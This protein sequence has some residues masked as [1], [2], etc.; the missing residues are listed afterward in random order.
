MNQAQPLSSFKNPKLQFVRELLRDRKARET[1][2]LFVV[3]GVRL[4]EEALR[5]PLVKPHM[6]LISPNLSER[7]RKLLQQKGFEPN[8]LIKIP[9]DVMDRLSDTET[10]QGVLLVIPQKIELLP[11]HSNLV[12]ILDQ[13]RDPGNMGTILR[14]AAA[15]GVGSVFTAPGSVDPYNP[16]VVR[17]AMGAHFH[18]PIIQADWSQIRE[19][20]KEKQTPPL[21][22]ILAEA[23]NGE[24][25]W[26]MNLAS[27]LAMIIGSEAYGSGAEA[28]SLAD[29]HVCIPMPGK[30]ESLNAGVAASL[31]LYEVIRQR[32][33]LNL[34]I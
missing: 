30:F 15:A 29:K 27:P 9:E 7:G 22:V 13:V 26:Q 23:Q 4:T 28:H 32:N 8:E 3:E 12:V 25:M 33:H 5:H 1:T 10:A 21:E 16:K 31:L 2:G 24:S 14:S 19:Y 17:A 18:S 11:Q 20:C 6:V 34:P